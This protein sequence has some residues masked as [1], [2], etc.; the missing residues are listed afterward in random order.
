MK[1][2]AFPTRRVGDRLAATCKHR[3]CRV[4]W[5]IA[6]VLS[7][8]GN[9]FACGP[10]FPN[11]LLDAG[12]HAV[13]QPPV[14]DFQREL[15]RMNL[16][17]T[18]L[19]AVPPAAG[20]N[21]Y[22]QSTEMEMTDLAAALKREKISSELATVILHSHLAER[23][24][25]NSFLKAQQEWEHFFCG[26]F[27][28]DKGCHALP[29]TNPPP[30]FPAIVVTP[31]L[32]REFALYFQ[33]AIAWQ[34]EERWRANKVWE[35]L[36]ALP[37]AARHFKSTWAEFMLGKY[38]ARQTNEL[39]EAEALKH[40]AQV[41]ALAKAG[42]ADSSGLAAAGF[43]EEAL[44]HLR[45]N[46]HER[47]I[48][49][50]LQQ[51][52]AGDDGAVQSLHVAAAG[53]VKQASST[54]ARLQQLARNPAARQ[55]I[56]AYLISR[57]PYIHRRDA[58][59]IPEAKQF[60]DVTAAWLEA[61]EAAGI[62]DLESAGLLALAAY[63]AGEMEAAQ[64]WINRAGGEP[65]AQW[66]QAKLLM[67][68]G[69]IPEA[70]KLLAKLSRSLPPELP[71]T[72]PPTRLADSLYLNICDYNPDH[73]AVGRQAL[74]ELG[75]LHLSR[76]EFAEALD[77]LLRS[78]YWVD[79]AYVAE[80]VLTTEELKKY[81]DQNWSAAKSK[82]E[83]HLENNYDW[84][85]GPIE[86]GRRLRYL[87]ARRLARENR[88]AE[89]RGYFPETWPVQLDW[90]TGK[91]R[92][93]RDETL[94]AWPRVN[95]L[96]A[97][98]RMMR[99]NGMELFG[100][101]LQPDWFVEGGNF[102]AG[103][104][105]EDRATNGPE[106]KINLASADEI[107]RAT[108]HGVEPEERWHYRE[109]SLQ[110]RD[111]ASDLAWEL[112]QTLPDNSD[113]TARLLCAAG[114]WHSDLSVR[115]KCYQALV[116]RCGKT[117]IGQQADKLRWFPALDGNGD[118]KE[119]IPWV[120]SVALTTDLTNSAATNG[121]GVMFFRYPIPGK[122][123]V[124]Q[125]GDTLLRIARAAGRLGPPVTLKQILQANP[126]TEPAKLRVGELLVIPQ[127][128]PGPANPAR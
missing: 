102:E 66:L 5:L 36:L 96:L 9:A 107:A 104:T 56:T 1:N 83:I 99:T 62:K 126:E 33:G 91:M 19:R 30:V 68:A 57:N 112:A 44:I 17:T 29:N 67:R 119:I 93:S 59:T 98:S 123:Y 71:G 28:D 16:V 27:Y 90:F 26:S 60:F 11:N 115:N 109:R 113:E 37:P 24:K 106:T 32:P 58:E 55:V 22:E 100:T 3:F 54:P 7:F 38:H 79:A 73:I 114:H 77:A 105:W 41:R 43:G 81:V 45:Q 72:N 94:R 63:Q 117:L 75:V 64:R 121:A 50:Y 76:R 20:Q 92:A 127:P 101:E 31:G 6:V 110:L 61:V 18:K 14:A 78:G 128:L 51:F 39:D 12:D 87:L 84:R 82:N 2:R 8:A 124:I 80:R 25:L 125:P 4:V 88:F 47:A 69:N 70:A 65:V 21:F 10:D 23:M 122:N 120:D 15:E 34:E 116:R 89:A 74:G 95:A 53:A 49:L 108:A 97:A 111:Q 85:Q 35:Q 48:E 40:F 118:L 103:V 46:D 52:A 42:F 86:V 13:L